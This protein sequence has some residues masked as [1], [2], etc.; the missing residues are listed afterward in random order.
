[1]PEFPVVTF[2]DEKTVAGSLKKIELILNTFVV[3]ENG[4]V[5]NMDG[6]CLL[7]AAHIFSAEKNLECGLTTL[8]SKTYGQSHLPAEIFTRI[9]DVLKL[10][11]N[12]RMAF[13]RTAVQQI[14][15]NDKSYEYNAVFE[16]MESYGFCEENATAPAY[17]GKGASLYAKGVGYYI[18]SRKIIEENGKKRLPPPGK[19]GLTYEN[20]FVALARREYEIE[21]NGRGFALGVINKKDFYWLDEH[22][23]TRLA[24][25]HAAAQYFHTG[26]WTDNILAGFL[27]GLKRDADLATAA[28]IKAVKTSYNPQSYITAC[29]IASA[30]SYRAAAYAVLFSRRTDPDDKQDLFELYICAQDN[31]EYAYRY[32]KAHD[33]LSGREKELL[34]ADINITSR[35]DLFNRIK[36]E[37][38]ALETALE[39]ARQLWNLKSHDDSGVAVW[40]G[41]YYFDRKEYKTAFN[42]FNKAYRN[43]RSEDLAW[44][45]AQ[46]YLHGYGTA[47][48]YTEASR[49]ISFCSSP[50]SHAA[51]ALFR[52]YGIGVPP[53][54]EEPAPKPQ[55]DKQTE[56]IVG[57]FIKAA[58]INIRNSRFWHEFWDWNDNYCGLTFS[59]INEKKACFRPFIEFCCVVYAM[60]FNGLTQTDNADFIIMVKC[61]R[62]EGGVF[63]NATADRLYEQYKNFNS[64]TLPRKPFSTRF[65]K[66]SRYRFYSGVAK[67]IEK[68]YAQVLG[69]LQNVYDGQDDSVRKNFAAKKYLPWMDELNMTLKSANLYSAARKSDL[70][71]ARKIYFESMENGNSN[72]ALYIYF[73]NEYIK[74]DS[75]SLGFL[76]IA[77]QCCDPRALVERAYLKEHGAISAGGLFEDY[78]KAIIKGSPHA[79]VNASVYYKSIAPSFFKA[80]K[81]RRLT[82]QNDAH[83]YEGG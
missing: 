49:Y 33:K 54:P 67:D 60:M 47:E 5:A 28:I 11:K 53:A 10:L 74:K 45:I 76:D 15:R 66:S 39:E 20:P 79:A 64:T 32:F 46:C 26:R 18:A 27:T 69:T 17:S 65:S 29:K 71:T 73:L 55:Y 57:A 59:N 72:A 31:N 37:P 8:D 13:V 12:K 9:T 25:R 44:H 41:N 56:Y 38:S 70:W 30:Y 63:A 43:F 2:S 78:C 3:S 22:T 40:L 61:M 68:Y 1:M 16:L 4:T 14:S 42:I 19:Y 36:N 35:L 48:N 75:V 34:G 58:N 52:V 80:S 24:F 6:D 81:I 77:A 62:S 82:E 50:E 21:K 7:T 51:A 23:K 83:N